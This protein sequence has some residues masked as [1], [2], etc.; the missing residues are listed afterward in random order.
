MSALQLPVPDVLTEDDLDRLIQ[1]AEEALRPGTIHSCQ[2][3]SS[4]QLNPGEMYVDRNVRTS[5]KYL[6][7]D[8]IDR[9]L[10]GCAFFCQLLVNSKL[11]GLKK[12]RTRVSIDG[13]EDVFELRPG[14]WICNIRILGFGCRYL[15]IYLVRIRWEGCTPEYINPT[16]FGLEFDVAAYKED[17]ASR[18]VQ[19]RP[20][21]DECSLY[22]AAGWAK[23]RIHD[24]EQSHPDC[25]R[26]DKPPF[27]P[28]RLLQLKSDNNGE[29]ILVTLQTS[30]RTYPKY[31]ALTYCWGGPQELRLTAETETKLRNG[32]EASSL[33]ATL[34]DAVIVTW[35]LGICFLWVDCLCIRQDDP[36]DLDVEISRIP[37][38]YGNSEVTISAARSSH[39]KEGFLYP[40]SFPLLDQTAY[41]LP[42]LCEDG[43]PGS[44]ILSTLCSEQPIDRGAW[45]FQEYLFSRRVLQFTNFPPRWTCTQ[46]D[47]HYN[48]PDD[49]AKLPFTVESTMMD[50][51][52]IREN[53]HCGSLEW[54]YDWIDIV[55]LYV[56]R[57]L[58]FD[59][60]RLK[61]ISGIAEYWQKR[62]KDR[63]VAGLWMSHLPT[64]L[65]WATSQNR[66][67]RHPEPSEYVAPSWSWA[68][69]TNM[70]IA[71][72]WW[73]GNLNKRNGPDLQILSC[74]VTPMYP[75]APFGAVTSGF[76][77]LHGRFKELRLSGEQQG[78]LERMNL[79]SIE[80]GGARITYREDT[81]HWDFKGAAEPHRPP[82]SLPLYALQ[83][84]VHDE[85]TATGPTGL[86]L[87][88]KDGT[89][90]FR[91][92]G[93][94]NFRVDDLFNPRW[95]VEQGYVDVKNY[96]PDE[97]LRLWQEQKDFFKD[98]DY[99]T[100]TIH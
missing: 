37:A 83:I 84:C 95:Q 91:R 65:L 97:A 3:C 79:E 62:T 90:A 30:V 28:S 43:R 56:K 13:G 81:L 100:I 9:A 41:K 31:T 26:T 85:S 54:Y 78:N 60:D 17:P 25:Q 34:G 99:K 74:S 14:T 48:E 58:T 66:N 51:R 76:L 55:E 32:V 96:D 88:K 19:H 12:Y 98:S 77:T 46:S 86:I 69:E 39:S 57:R 10:K 38:I 20:F 29:R 94:F 75:Q 52:S 23:A 68:S 87:A 70:D 92:I 33:V 42:F 4:L 64:G 18:T 71:C 11:E 67:D 89:D 21:Y 15:E 40:P 27:R 50:V 44:V 49:E 36:Y 35:H 59:T 1:V 72:T 63:Y 73:C 2:V 82:K 16:R 53:L 22:Q 93:L 5:V 45:T 61:A 7:T 8:V 24:C 6:G 80:P 47:L